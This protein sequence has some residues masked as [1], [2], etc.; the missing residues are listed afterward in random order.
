MVALLLCHHLPGVAYQRRML[1][2]NGK[3]AQT[4]CLGTH[5]HRKT[6]GMKRIMLI[7]HMPLHN[8]AREAK[9]NTWRINANNVCN[10]NCNC[11]NLKMVSNHA[12]N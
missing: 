5:I 6:A 3:F 10:R 2:N 8:R 4:Y 9:D 12:M 7:K 11:L 1:D